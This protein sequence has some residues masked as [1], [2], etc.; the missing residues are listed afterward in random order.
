MRSD[1]RLL[2]F[3]ISNRWQHLLYLKC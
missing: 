3:R 2:P 1:L